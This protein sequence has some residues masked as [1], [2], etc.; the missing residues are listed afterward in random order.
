M[1]GLCCDCDCAVTDWCLRP[2]GMANSCLQVKD[3]YQMDYQMIARLGGIGP[4]VHAGA[5]ACDGS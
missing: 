5:D 1:T 2:D 4:T 3:A